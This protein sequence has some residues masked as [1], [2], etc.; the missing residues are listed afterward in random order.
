MPRIPDDETH[1]T[2]P[3]RPILDE[4]P[5]P[6]IERGRAQEA[7]SQALDALTRAYLLVEATAMAVARGLDSE[8]RP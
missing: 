5:V 3:M 7:M 4:V 6:V 2:Q 8:V 1:D